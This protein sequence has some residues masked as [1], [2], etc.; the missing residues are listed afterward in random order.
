MKKVSDNYQK[1]QKVE[2]MKLDSL[3][4]NYL[5]IHFAKFCQLSD[6]MNN[7]S[8]EVLKFYLDVYLMLRDP[9]I[10]SN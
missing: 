7:L 10:Q 9:E 5:I 6:S 8:K 3:R 2:L 1:K 4:I